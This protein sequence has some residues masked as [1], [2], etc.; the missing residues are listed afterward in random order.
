[1]IFFPAIV[2]DRNEGITEYKYDK[3]GEPLQKR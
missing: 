1:L 3:K 2:V